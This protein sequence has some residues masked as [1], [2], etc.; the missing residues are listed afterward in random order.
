M[1]VLNTQLIQLR[2]ERLKT[3]RFSGFRTLASAITVQ[4][5]AAPTKTWL[6]RGYKRLQGVRRGYE[7]LRGV[8]KGYRGLQEV[9]GS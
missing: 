4:P 6:L 3:F 7:G 8:T 9:T 2:K 1:N 5:V